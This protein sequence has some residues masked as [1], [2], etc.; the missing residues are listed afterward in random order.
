MAARGRNLSRRL[1]AIR[2]AIDTTPLLQTRAG[3]ARYLRGL[4]D[5]LDVDIEE[6]QFAATSRL[7]S[8]AADVAWYP[9]LRPRGPADV[10]HCP[11][12]RGPF[13]SR[14]PLVVTVHDLAV[15]AHPEW[16][17]RWTATYSRFAVPRVVAAA[18]RV[19]AVSP[20]TS[21]ELQSRLGVPEAK[22]RV[23]P[24]AVEDVFTPDGPA[25]AGD[26]FLAVGTLEPRKNLARI[27][28]A[29]DGELRVVGAAGWGGVSP[30]PNVTWL[31]PVSDE[32]ARK[33]V[34]RCPL[35]GVRIVVRGVRDPGRRS[36]RL[37][38][39]RR[40]E[41]R[42]AD[43]GVGR[44]RCD[45]RRPVRCRVDSRGHR[46]GEPAGAAADRDVVRGRCRHPLRL[47]RARVIVIDADV[48]GRQRTGEETYVLNLLRE[49]PRA[50]PDLR[51]AAVTRHPE[52]VPE[53]IEPILL[54]ARSQELRMAWSLPRLLRRLRPGLSHFQHALPLGFSGRAVV[55][56]HDLHFEYDTQVMG[57]LDRLTFKAVV[58]R[59]A[60]RARAVLAVSERTRQ[61]AIRLYGLAP[62]KVTVTPHGVDPAFSYDAGEGGQGGYL[63]FVGAV[64]ERKNPLAAVAAAKGAGLPLVVA[65]PEKEPALAR[66]L[67][68]GGRRRAWASSTSPSS[69]FSTAGRL[70]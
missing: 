5:Q 50:A 22:I 11:T 56:L 49:L 29:V 15:L 9:R 59:A 47:R 68:D 14:T 51:F 55:T 63:L 66:A 1:R 42:L 13:R 25:A 60:R 69:P 62:D 8:V 67:R 38:L 64:Q 45:L 24:N 6:L 18:D 19:I 3:T 10:L 58:P 41:R 48:L 52:L 37:R 40:D 70:R 26:F 65:G 23:V 57:R 31:G 17:N 35:P 27:A 34:P 36:A 28:A 2:V 4:L 44:R 43:G 20:H 12:F 53:G 16:F 39:C 30:P 32:R 21:R 61:D 7:R 33:P 46:A 54:A